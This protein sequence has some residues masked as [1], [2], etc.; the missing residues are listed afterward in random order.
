MQ[1][2]KYN[3]RDLPKVV[4]KGIESET[5]VPTTC[6][7]GHVDVTIPAKKLIDKTLILETKLMAK[8]GAVH[9]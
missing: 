3:E 5:I 8:Y 2:Q 1:D 7:I 6:E 4:N 9:Y